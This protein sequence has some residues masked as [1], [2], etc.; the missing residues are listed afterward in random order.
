MLQR[1]F[2][3]KC[4]WFSRSVVHGS[5]DCGFDACSRSNALKISTEYSRHSISGDHVFSVRFSAGERSWTQGRPGRGDF[6]G[7]RS[8]A[9]LGSHLVSQSC[10][11]S[12]ATNRL[13]VRD[14]GEPGEGADERFAVLL[15]HSANLRRAAEGL[16]CTGNCVIS[17]TGAS[18]LR[19]SFRRSLSRP[20]CAGPLR[21]GVRT[22]GI[23]SCTS[24]F[25]FFFIARIPNRIALHYATG[26][27][28]PSRF[29][30]S[31]SPAV[32]PPSARLIGRSGASQPCPVHRPPLLHKRAALRAGRSHD[33]RVH[34]SEN[35]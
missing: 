3:G 35:N 30:H 12:K 31:R 1:E 17:F 13:A 28:R 23:E 5:G 14:C 19:F 2:T 21:L 25:L 4:G 11:R 33:W 10:D 6:L 26:W 32:V 15:P 27:P 22:L 16:H 20:H 34:Q 8:F 18:W 29:R 24:R 7:N 9:A